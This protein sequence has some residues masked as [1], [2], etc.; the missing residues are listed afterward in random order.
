MKMT[1]VGDLIVAVNDALLLSSPVVFVTRMPMLVFVVTS[2]RGPGSAE[3]VSRVVDPRGDETGLRT[4]P[5][6]PV[7]SIPRMFAKKFPQAIRTLT[8]PTL[9]TLV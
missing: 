7:A 9:I 3:P 2:S 5:A 8:S 4:V 1:C 6:G